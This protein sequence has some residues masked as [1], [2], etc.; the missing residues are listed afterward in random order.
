MQD[1]ARTTLS[2]RYKCVPC[3][4]QACS[5][6]AR[7]S[8]VNYAERIRPRDAMETDRVEE[9]EY[10]PFTNF[11]NDSLVRITR[12]ELT[13]DCM[14]PK[15]GVNKKRWTMAILP[16]MCS[17]PKCMSVCALTLC[18]F[19]DFSEVRVRDFLTGC[20]RFGVIIDLDIGGLSLCVPSC[21]KETAVRE[22]R[23]VKFA[24]VSVC[25]KRTHTKF[26]ALACPV[27][28][29]FNP[30]TPHMTA[31]SLTF[32][33]VGNKRKHPSF[34]RMEEPYP[35]ARDTGS[36][37]SSPKHYRLKCPQCLTASPAIVNNSDGGQAS[38]WM[39]PFFVCSNPKCKFMWK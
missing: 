16:A 9:F 5:A 25:M 27:R 1:E 13:I 36:D 7:Y 29:C 38:S 30:I 8:I 17:N 3:P 24:L 32:A 23:T 6:L 21:E 39:V 18:G 22:D 15:C 12:S 14:N 4:N 28:D 34:Q 33:C 10:D 11:S 35:G 20:D 37:A 2:C 26:S 31:D 19:R